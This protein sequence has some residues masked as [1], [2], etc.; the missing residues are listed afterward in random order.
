MDEFAALVDGMPLLQYG[1]LDRPAEKRALAA[2]M[3]RAAEL[4]P[5]TYVF[6]REPCGEAAARETCVAVDDYFKRA[7]K[8]TER[9]QEL[10]RAADHDDARVLIDRARAAQIA[11][12]ARL[13]QGADPVSGSAH[14]AETAGLACVW[15][16]ARLDAL[17]AMVAYYEEHG[18]F[19]RGEPIL[20]EIAQSKRYALAGCEDGVGGAGAAPEFDAA[21]FVAASGAEHDALV[22]RASALLCCGRGYVGEQF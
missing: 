5:K 20:A 16:R 12:S 21:A 2:A 22:V 6:P 14:T 7:Q 1:P 19:G 17:T 3:E 13:V 9:A 10:R 4:A 15:T 11:F 8:W 18:D